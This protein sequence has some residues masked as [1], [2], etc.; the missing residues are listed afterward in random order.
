MCFLKLY[1][2]EGA[3]VCSNNEAAVSHVRAPQVGSSVPTSN[4]NFQS[5]QTLAGTAQVAGLPPLLCETW[6]GLQFSA[7]APVQPQR[8]RPSVE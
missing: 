8:L 7:P 3:G 6:T 2:N 4:S 5:T 1:V